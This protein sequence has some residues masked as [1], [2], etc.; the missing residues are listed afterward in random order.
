MKK[1]SLLLLICLLSALGIRAQTSPITP[2]YT[3]LSFDGQYIYYNDNF[4]KVH[5]MAVTPIRFPGVPTGTCLGTST[6]IDTANGSLYY[7]KNNSWV[8]STSNPSHGVGAPTGPCAAGNLYTDDS[9]GNLY[10][11]DSGTWALVNGSVGS[12][13][14][15][16]VQ[17]N[18]VSA[19]QRPKLNLIPGTNMTIACLDNAG[20]LSTDCTLTASVT[21]G[22]AFSALTAATNTN[23]GPFI[24]VGNGWDFSGASY[25]AVPVGAGL[26]PGSN[27][28]I[29]FN[30]TNNS[31]VF[32]SNG[33]TLTWPQNTTVVAHQFITGYNWVTG[34]FSQAQ[35]VVGD[36]GGTISA[37]LNLNSNI[38]SCPTCIVA[39][40]PVAG[41]GHF[42]GSTQ[43]ITSSAIT[44]ADAT[45][46]TS[47]SGS[48][49]LT[50]SCVMTTPNL[51]TPS[52]IV[53]TNATGAPTWNQ[54]TTGSAAK[55]TTARNL[56]GNSV[57]GSANVAFAN[58]F[59]V[60]GTT[61]TGLS[62]PQFLGALGTGILKNTTTT[63]VL[64]IA[65]AGDFPTL[66]QTTTGTA[67]GLTG[68]TPSTAGSICIWNG[69]A[70]GLFAG[71][72]GSTALL[73]ESGSGVA[74]WVAGSGTGTVVTSGSPAQYQVSYFTDATTITGT[75]SDSTVSH[76]L[77]ATAT[78]P[79]FRA[80]LATD[81]PAALSSSTSVNGT[82][83]PSSVTLAYLGASAQTFTNGITAPTFTSNVA[84]GTA[85]FTVT[86]TTNVPNLN[87][88]S[89]SGAT[90]AAPGPIG[91]GTASTGAFTT[92][93]AS[94][95]VSGSGFSA[96]LA[97]PPAIGGTAPAAGTFTTVTAPSVSTSG[98]NGGIS[99]TEGTCAI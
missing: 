1:L 67:G 65:I 24:A 50:T 8:Q 9:T 51:G 44:V 81:L 73:Q 23:V 90:F 77:F 6:A 39:S 15:Q 62:G 88:S 94:S 71:N 32:G 72:S 13:F 64:S 86:S 16:T 5:S 68:C 89:L 92:L 49:C 99:G 2:G 29:G 59:I 34:A 42:A 30:S 82:T 57:D 21:A 47:G 43:T 27:G 48:F 53:L 98:S 63:G 37:P 69:S 75:A 22:T 4:G 83:I 14:Y 20:N 61:D 84:I 70:W 25:F 66:N 79:A 85:P 31:P 46:S 10:A 58:K 33:A 40:S 7:C 80:I 74:S 19:T 26:A 35:P 60:Q 76:A 95:T 93:S 87:A 97:S 41:V 12:S 36:L 54:N 17:V 28:Y 55:W 11:C 78:A 91:S 3:V 18:T 45:G 38:L 52:A 96:Y 56:A